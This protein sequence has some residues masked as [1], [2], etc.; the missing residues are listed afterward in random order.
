VETISRE[1]ALFALLESAPG[2]LFNC[3]S[4]LN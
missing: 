3:R 1:P 2:K 4:K